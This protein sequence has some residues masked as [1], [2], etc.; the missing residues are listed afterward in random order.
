[1]MACTAPS[2]TAASRAARRWTAQARLTEQA[3]GLDL[4]KP[5]E[6]SVMPGHPAQVLIE[7]VVVVRDRG[8]SAIPSHAAPAGLLPAPGPSGR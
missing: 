6:E 3:L 5:I 8:V 7:P 2:R 1:M 4:E